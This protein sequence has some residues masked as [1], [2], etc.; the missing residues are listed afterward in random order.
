M[1]LTKK[2]IIVMSWS[3]QISQCQLVKKQ[4]KYRSVSVVNGT[5]RGT[6][7]HVVGEERTGGRGGGGRR[8]VINWPAESV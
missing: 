6:K 1:Q 8:S 7:D 4:K 2:C 5:G 3:T